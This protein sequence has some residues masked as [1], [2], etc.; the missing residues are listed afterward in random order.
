MKIIG[1][2]SKNISTNPFVI[3][4]LENKWLV[5]LKDQFFI[6]LQFPGIHSKVR[7]LGSWLM[8]VRCDNMA[9][10]GMA[11]SSAF[12]WWLLFLRAVFPPRTNSAMMLSHS[13]VLPAFPF[14]FPLA[15]WL[16]SPGHFMVTR[17]CPDPDVT[18][19]SKL[20]SKAKRARP[21]VCLYHL[22]PL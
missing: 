4:I 6:H 9:P 19:L 2:H 11:H 10:L 18:S 15:Y 14:C 22:H 3:H 21:T 12:P 16:L 5:K 20:G 17:G 7:I 1:S 8:I 13:Q